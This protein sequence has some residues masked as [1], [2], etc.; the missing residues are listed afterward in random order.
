MKLLNFPDYFT[1]FYGVPRTNTAMGLA[2]WCEDYP[3]PVTFLEPLLY[4]PNILPQGNSN[5]AELDDP[6]VNKAIEEASAIPIDRPAAEQAW[7][8]ANKLATETAPWIPVHWFLDDEVVSD[9]V[10]GAYW[11]Q[12]YAAIDWPNVGVKS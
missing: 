8:D 3:S 12:Y 5:H 11:H 9:K 1:Q 10:V 4:G 7:I 6:T 2:A